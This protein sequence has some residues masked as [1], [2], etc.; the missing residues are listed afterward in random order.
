MSITTSSSDN[1]SRARSVELVRLNLIGGGREV[2]FKPGLNIVQG[3]ISSGKTTFVR[4][5][6]SLLGAVPSGLPPETEF[7]STLLG[8]IR[9]SQH[10]WKIF[11]PLVTTNNAP[12]DVAEVQSDEEREAVAFR[13]PAGGKGQPYSTFLLEQ[14]SIPA[15]SVPRARSKPTE[16]VTPVTMT[17]WLGYCVVTGDEIDTQVFGHHHPF[18]D[19][20]RRAVFELAYGYYNV[21]AARKAA[22][23]R[24]IELRL[25]A[26]DRDSEAIRTLLSATPFYDAPALEAELEEL[27]RQLEG[28]REA[29]IQLGVDVGSIPGVSE[30]RSSVIAR[31]NE[32]AEML[33]DMRRI[34]VQLSDLRDLERQ[35]KSQAA[36]LTR[37]VV[38]DEWLVDFDFVVCPRCGSDINHGRV[39][40]DHCYLC[41]QEPRR[42]SS[43]DDLLAEQARVSEQVAETGEVIQ[44]RLATLADLRS[45]LRKLES[46]IGDAAAQ[47]DQLTASYVS[48]NAQRLEYFAAK[49]ADLEANI[50]RLLE[51]LEVHQKLRIRDEERTTLEEEREQILAEISGMELDDATPEENVK[52]LEKRMLEYLK[53]LNIPEFEDGLS[54]KI[55]RSNYLPIISGRDFDKLSSQGLKTLVNIA[56]AL[57]H[58]TV[59]IDRNLPMP[60]LLVLDG[61]SANAGYEGFDMARVSDIYRLLQRI[62][63]DYRNALQLVAV[64]NELPRGLLLDLVDRVILTVDHNDRL[65]RIPG[66][67]AEDRGAE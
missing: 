54:V 48:D 34:E 23:L 17:D 52:A 30:L 1:F 58:H 31:R 25:E 11:R 4:L 53:F 64:D 62:D 2:Y 38:A 57:A 40:K 9:L 3:E 36:R 6:R 65:I 24:S 19:G 27:H 55:N 59:A 29:Q 50:K 7:I 49:E 42:A 16:S 51:Y 14:L 32:Q 8:D 56:H 20:K 12:V 22:E 44:A 43:R 47:L 5:I 10:E 41:M 28:I 18:R 60:G 39:D 21:E 61:L 66:Q 37:A 13:L 67:R 45:R 33:E 35:L 15:V 46:S 26:I 63:N